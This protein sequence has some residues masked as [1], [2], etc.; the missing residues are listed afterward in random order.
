MV[1]EVEK[2]QERYVVQKLKELMELR[3]SHPAFG[4]D[5]S[6]SVETDTDRLVI[7]RSCGEHSITLDADLSTYDFELK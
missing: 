7:T 6:I 4:L 2:Q 3:N 5:G 1:E